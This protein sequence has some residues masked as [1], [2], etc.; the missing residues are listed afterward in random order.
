MAAS[1]ARLWDAPGTR[2]TLEAS[3]NSIHTGAWSL[4][5]CLTAH[6]AIDT[7]GA[8]AI[9]EGGAQGDVSSRKPASRSHRCRL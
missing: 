3:R 7:G 9:D 1:E 4:R 5:I 8:K 2:R 6:T